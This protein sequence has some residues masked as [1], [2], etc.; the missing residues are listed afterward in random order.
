MQL[1]D[2]QYKT[3]QTSPHYGRAVISSLAAHP[4]GTVSADERRSD[5]GDRL[6]LAAVRAGDQKH[7]MELRDALWFGG[8]QS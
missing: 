7:L 6:F 5:I 3:L 2:T 1:T 8:G 4:V